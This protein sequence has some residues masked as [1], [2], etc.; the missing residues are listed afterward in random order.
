MDCSS[1]ASRWPK[2]QHCG[3]VRVLKVVGSGNDGIQGEW[4][5]RVVPG[6]LADPWLEIETRTGERVTA[7]HSKTRVG[8]CPDHQFYA[9]MAQCHEVGRRVIRAARVITDDVFHAPGGT[10][11]LCTAFGQHDGPTGR[12]WGRSS[13]ALPL[14]TVRHGRRQD[15]PVSPRLRESVKGCL[16]HVLLS[17]VGDDERSAGTRFRQVVLHASGSRGCNGFVSQG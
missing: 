17:V 11:S 15:Q 13:T 6:Q 10:D 8:A 9:A 3:D 12:L 5:C 7:R 14:I 16:H 4:V 1:C 2:N